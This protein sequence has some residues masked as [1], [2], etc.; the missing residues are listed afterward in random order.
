MCVY[1]VHGTIT[2]LSQTNVL[3][4]ARIVVRQDLPQSSLAVETHSPGQVNNILLKVDAD[5]VV[6]SREGWVARNVI[7]TACLGDV[8]NC[9]DWDWGDEPELISWDP[10]S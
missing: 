8:K 7:V 6:W 9:R 2:W 4:S 5:F 1:E 3:D 10:W